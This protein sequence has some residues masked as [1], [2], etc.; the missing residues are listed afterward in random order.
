MNQQHGANSQDQESALR[1]S[2]FAGLSHQYEVKGFVRLGEAAVED[3]LP[4]RTGDRLEVFTAPN[5]LK[6]ITPAARQLKLAR[7][8]RKA[9][10][11]LNAGYELLGRMRMPAH[12][13][14]APEQVFVLGARAEG[15]HQDGTIAGAKLDVNTAELMEA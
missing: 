15:I 12:F 9:I 4:N 13:N 1:A 10:A 11:L 6:P 5:F 8:K 3:L 2:Y 7:D 14:D